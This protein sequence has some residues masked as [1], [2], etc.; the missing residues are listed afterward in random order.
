[1][2]TTITWLHL[3]DLHACPGRTGWDA[4]HIMKSLCDDLKELQQKH[5]LRPD[6]VFFTGDAAFGQLGDKS[7]ISLE[8][9][10][11]AVQQFL[12]RIRCSFRPELSPRDVYLVPGNHD[13]NRDD[14]DSAQT[15]WLRDPNRS[16]DD[17]ISMMQAGKAQWRRFME[18]LEDYKAFLK[19]NGYEHLLTDD[20]NRLIYADAR[21]VA[22]LR[23]G[24]A[25]LNS[26]W[27][28]F[29]GVEEK[30]HL[31]CGGK[32]QVEELQALLSKADF[33]IALIHHP[34]NW[35]VAREDP[36][37]QRLL[38]ASFQ[39][40]LHGHEHQ[41]WVT[42]NAKTGHT[43]VWAGPCYDRSD[44]KNGFNIVQL[45]R[46]TGTGRVWL[47]EYKETGR[48]WVACNIKA[49]A[50]RGIWALDRLKWFRKLKLPEG[51]ATHKQHQ[52]IERT[53]SPKTEHGTP[54]SAP[55]R[56]I[57]QE[58]TADFER[59]L[60][61][62]MVRKY[63]YLELFGADIP[64]ESQ[65]HALSVAYVSLNLCKEDEL[66]GDSD[67]VSSSATTG[68]ATEQSEEADS[69][70]GARPVDEVFDRLSPSTG[71]LLIRGVA[72]GGKSTLLRWAA[73][74]AARFN[75]EGH[76]S[77][78]DVGTTP[79]YHGVFEKRTLA[80]KSATDVVETRVATS[81]LGA[82]ATL[83]EHGAGGKLQ[84]A[85]PSEWDNWRTKIP[86]LMRLRDCPD[87]VLPRPK[88]LPA[89]IAK[90][91]PDPPPE[92]IDKV[93]SDGRGLLLFD[94]V[95]EVPAEKRDL[96]SR[97]IE[98]LINAY[99]KDYYIVSTRPGAVDSG[100]LSK[101]GFFEARIE[102]MSADDQHEFIDK[103]YSAVSAELRA[104]GRRPENLDKLAASL[105]QE[106][107]E[108]PNIAKLAIYPLLCAM[109]CALY[110]ERNQKLPETQAALCE[111]L[112][113]ILLHRRERETPDMKLVHLPPDYRKLDYEH[114][115]YIVAELAKFMVENGV[116][117]LDEHQA[118]LLLES[119]L[120]HFPDHAQAKPQEIRRA[121]IERSGL[122]RPSGANRIDFLHN[123]LKE[124]LSAGRFV[125]DGAYKLLATHAED[126]AW[127]PVILFASALPTPG[128][129]SKL[130][131][132]LLK[133]VRRANRG[134]P[135]PPDSSGA[136]A[137]IA[138]KR[139][140]EFFV[141]RCRNA[142]FRLEPELVGRV[143]RL[144]SGLFPPN[145][146]A[147]A[148]AL[149]NIGD[150]IVPHLDPK[151]HLT[152]RQKIAC[153]RA[154][155]L[156][157]GP[158]AKAMLKKF[159]PGRTKS[160]LIELMTASAELGATV[161][162]ANEHLDLSCSSIRDLSP[163]K[164]QIAL[165]TLNLAETK[166]TDLSPVADLAG[167]E[168]ISLARTPVTD[169][170]PLSMLP[171]LQVL[172]LGGTPARDFSPLSGLVS[173]QV[174][175]LNRTGV[176]SH[177]ILGDIARGFPDIDEFFSYLDDRQLMH[178]DPLEWHRSRFFELPA[179][180]QHAVE[181]GTRAM[182]AESRERIL[183]F[184]SLVAR[185]LTRS[186][187]AWATSLDS[188]SIPGVLAAADM[189]VRLTSYPDL[190]ERWL[191]EIPHEWHREIDLHALKNSIDRELSL[192]RKRASRAIRSVLTPL[193]N[194]HN[195]KAL[196]LDGQQISNLSAISG[197]RRLK[198]LNLSRTVVVDLSPLAR[199]SGLC[200]L[201]LAGCPITSVSSLRGL[202]GL[203]HLDL[204]G[205][206]IIDI[207]PLRSL[208][209]LQWL[210]L[211][212]TRVTDLSPLKYLPSLKALF[213]P[214]ERHQGR[215]TVR[216]QA[217]QWKELK[218]ANP[219]LQIDLFDA[220]LGQLFAF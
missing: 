115:K 166:V 7:G 107:R 25:G 111:D 60:C 93:L 47:R 72:G 66:E 133:G 99:P 80:Q 123:T 14:I 138:V 45:N 53:T 84:D 185:P 109:I 13:V 101:L 48:G 12:D 27:S 211:A 69:F 86:F 157:Q 102:P 38:E 58:K 147:D 62:A 97:E 145:T 168:R 116:S 85:K 40:V 114:K 79:D 164:A 162:L 198:Y 176:Y 179:R 130:V 148:E 139:N 91:L 51:A 49:F 132:E 78:G 207:S 44:R 90:E 105:K 42:T 175:S 31:W 92:W 203:T 20:K 149:A 193:S 98:N 68:E 144:A 217:Q 11:K 129:A 158:K 171:T 199:T 187:Y 70:V 46:K 174:L 124:Y 76:G 186:M 18:R 214:G 57:A 122:L 170:A 219:R 120:Q 36:N 180:L 205:T 112:C 1:M 30:G 15:L 52:R 67:L 218:Q 183:W 173:L 41:G 10:Y 24:I 159:A 163:L 172:D 35:F 5:K 190:F 160:V 106:L 125:A 153:I 87:G 195:L 108:T 110:R 182:P 196:D 3:S 6:F 206:Q 126:D 200:H 75:L 134:T 151:Q 150:A 202:K 165:R 16:L 89:I 96:L 29:G 201:Y 212:G 208:T 32:Y 22:G 4:N 188:Y 184:I 50:P 100:W 65:R 169:L 61:E 215:R 117:S 19:S 59:R 140:R 95:D 181:Y 23:V 167:L 131:R 127:Q 63:D 152:S 119:A 204:T 146:I 143:N 213:V 55:K 8:D 34:G 191:S 39:F 33:S 28:C 136:T 216:G 37:V 161:Q 209:S 142:A 56:V 21:E 82:P 141:V 71:R 178:R 83:P 155:R 177:F 26:A 121:L 154:L 81:D 210:S 77:P 17:I 156:V 118:D 189:L 103:W 137:P 113:K 43:T 54:S 88:D 197:L 64:R 73:I 9:Q 194:L 135:A 220:R 192:S 104:S 94:G 128:F 2:N 74:Q